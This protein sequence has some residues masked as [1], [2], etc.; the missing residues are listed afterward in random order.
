MSL[1]PGTRLGAYEIVALI[2]AGGMGEVYRARDSR[3]GRDVAIKVLPDAFASDADRV[4]RFAREAQVLASLNHPHIG[5]IYGLEDRALVLELVE[6]PTLADR[7]ARGALPLDEAL[8][9]ARQIC[10][11]L[12]AAHEH[13][14]VHRDLKPANIK[15]TRDGNVKVL[16]FGLAKASS[17]AESGT[18]D[19]DNSPTITSAGTH[20]GI[21]LGTAAYMSPEQARGKPIDKRTDIWAFGCVLFEMLSGTRAFEGSDVHDVLVAVL[22]KEPRWD[23]LGTNVPPSIRNL[24][25]RCLQKDRRRRLADIADARIEIEDEMNPSGVHR[26]PEV[27]LNAAP[28]NRLRHYG[29]P[30]AVAAMAVLSAGALSLWPLSRTT[31]APSSL[32]RVNAELGAPVSLVTA[33][34]AGAI[35]SPDGKTLAFVGQPSVGGGAPQIYLRGLEQLS[36]QPLAGTEGAMNPFFSP[37][38]RWIGFFSAGKLKKAAVSGGGSIALADAANGRGGSWG[39]DD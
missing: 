18:V 3:L 10:D 37:D 34:G 2:G 8:A 27:V 38:G 30:W 4:T 28:R 11:A 7:I 20:G 26:A 29:L 15:L 32:V 35:L 12:E 9:I 31:V 24:L 6:G 1:A 23:A 16:D 22:S 13:G 36:A 5:A 33:Q 19:L 25:R 21:I 14:I 17:P 39:D